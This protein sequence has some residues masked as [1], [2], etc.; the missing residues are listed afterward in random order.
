MAFFENMDPEI[1]RIIMKRQERERLER[2]NG[3]ERKRF[4]LRC[5]S[6]GG[7][8]HHSRRKR[9]VTLPTLSILDED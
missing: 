6:N 9:K 2:F 8:Q 1:F 4:I 5:A 7:M 3:E